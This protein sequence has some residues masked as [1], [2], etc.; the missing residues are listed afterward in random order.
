M[1]AA[2]LI[3]AFDRH[4]IARQVEALALL[5]SWSKDGRDDQGARRP[6]IV[7]QRRVG[8]DVPRLRRHRVLPVA[9]AFEPEAIVARCARAQRRGYGDDGVRPG[10]PGM[11]PPA[12]NLAA[13]KLRRG[14]I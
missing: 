12:F 5:P 9:R 3:V 2:P 6:A 8:T 7:R 1:L 10:G 11:A 4:A 14:E 13:T